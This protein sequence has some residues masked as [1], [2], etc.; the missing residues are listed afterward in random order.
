MFAALDAEEQAR[1]SET[2]NWIHLTPAPLDRLP[3]SFEVPLTP[4]LV[5]VPPEALEYLSSFSQTLVDNVAGP[6]ST[7][8]TWSQLS[9]PPA[10]NTR[11]S[12]VPTRNFG[13]SFLKFFLMTS[14]LVSNSFILLLFSLW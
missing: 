5:P 6:N 1:F 11:G 10:S 4:W 13:K 7:P 3:S 2:F 14:C 8:N 9:G 12:R